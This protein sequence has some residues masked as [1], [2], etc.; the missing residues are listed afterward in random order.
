MIYRLRFV[1]LFLIFTILSISRTE[2]HGLGYRIKGETTTPVVTFSYSD[3]KPASYG[4]VTVWSPADKTVEFQNGRTDK[5][6]RFAFSPD[7][8]GI[9]RIELSDG[10][11]HATSAECTVGKIGEQAASIS[12][13]GQ[14]QQQSRLI[15][16]IL[17]ISLILNIAATI[18]FRTLRVNSTSASAGP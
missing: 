8:A 7:T 3:G 2:A 14:T 1:Y 9:W 16:I 13:N 11:G 10:M 15:P 6:G 4:E 18:K 17:G 12:K 5:N